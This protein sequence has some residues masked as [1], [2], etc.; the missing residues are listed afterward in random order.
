MKGRNHKNENEGEMCLT[1]GKEEVEWKG[2]DIKAKQENTREYYEGKEAEK[3]NETKENYMK[4]QR[5]FFKNRV[6][7][8]GVKI[9][10]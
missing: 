10:K 2:N 3:K 8:P 4:W 1:N 7:E 6:R 9:E 5:K